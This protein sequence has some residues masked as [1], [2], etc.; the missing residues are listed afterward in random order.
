M[1]KLDN[2]SLLVVFALQSMPFGKHALV[3]DTGH[4]N[5]ASD[6]PVENDMAAALYTA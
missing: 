1:I 3:Q 5:T 6:C 2:V 4:Q